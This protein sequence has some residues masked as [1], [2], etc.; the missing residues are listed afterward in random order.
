MC[1]T[2]MKLGMKR[3][4]YSSACEWLATGEDLFG[5]EVQEIDVGFLCRVLS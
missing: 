3:V 2:R 1:A 4:A 5:G